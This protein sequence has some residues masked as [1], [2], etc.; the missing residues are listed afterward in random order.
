MWLYRYGDL[1]FFQIIIKAE[2]GV[3]YVSDIAIDDVSF[4]PECLQAD[5]RLSW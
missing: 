4:T 3:T 5:G 2:R 1:A